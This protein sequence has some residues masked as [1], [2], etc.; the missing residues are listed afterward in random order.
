MATEVFS[1]LSK[2]ESD[3]ENGNAKINNNFSKNLFHNFQ[4]Q[5]SYKTFYTCNVAGSVFTTLHFL[6]NIRISPVSWIVLS[7]TQL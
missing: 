6:H 7:I 5:R 1:Q 4:Q 2:F 3:I